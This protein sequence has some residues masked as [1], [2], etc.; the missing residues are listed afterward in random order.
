MSNIPDTPIVEEKKRV[1]ITGDVVAGEVTTNP[2]VNTPP[3]EPKDGE[4]GK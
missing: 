2:E 1:I 4:Q 3:E